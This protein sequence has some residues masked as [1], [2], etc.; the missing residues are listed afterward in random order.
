[1]ESWTT[2]NLKEHFEGLLEEKDKRYQQRFNDT[3]IAVDAALAAAEKAVTKAETA[4]DKRFESVNEFR[5]T[6]ADQ[7]RT[8]MPRAEIE[9]LMKAQNDKI[10]ALT[11][12]QNKTEGKTV[13]IGQTL[14]YII[15]AIGILSGVLA[16][17]S[18]LKG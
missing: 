14:G 8:L 18:R 1:M 5:N 4:A 6:L 2:E 7:Q 16:L 13:G 15:G 11:T 17:A 10:T 3:K 9:V 12:N